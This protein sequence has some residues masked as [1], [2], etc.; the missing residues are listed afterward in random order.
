MDL[1][2]TLKNFQIDMLIQG[3]FLGGG[4]ESIDGNSMILSTANSGYEQLRMIFFDFFKI[5]EKDVIVDVGCGKGRVFNFLLYK[6]LKNK[7]IGYE[8]NKT[9][10]EKTKKN[11]SRYG[12]V[13]IRS[14]NI[15]NDFPTEGNIFYLFNPFREAMM[16]DFKK[17]ILQI[18][19]KNPVILY[20]N[21]QYLDIFNDER[22]TYDLKDIPILQSGYPVKLALIKLS[23]KT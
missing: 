21:P 2:K 16:K 19:E 20:Y 14:E 3:S 23:D 7:M 4:V 12:N 15:F 8:I 5:R 1:L 10:A 6:G 9:V 13:D 17:R 22:F 11:L 18:R